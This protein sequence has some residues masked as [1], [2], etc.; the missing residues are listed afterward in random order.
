MSGA[1]KLLAL[2]LGI[3]V[4]ALAAAGCGGDE[5][6]SKAAWVEQ[7]DGICATSEEVLNQA[8]ED[9]FGGTA[10]D[11]DDQASFVTDEVV[12]S[13][14]SQHDEIAD[15]ASPEG[16][17]QQADALLAA[18]QTAIDKLE[19]DPASITEAGAKAPLTEANQLAD[20]FGLTDC[21]G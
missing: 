3:L 5:T 13:L 15:L 16:A 6:Q 14:Q 4:A 1:A 21:G 19:A 2:S 7:A 17:E 12:P 20:E 11:V 8:A 10:P 9:Q 18:L